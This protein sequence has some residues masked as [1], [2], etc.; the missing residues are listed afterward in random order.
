MPFR[1]GLAAARRSLAG[2]SLNVMNALRQNQAQHQDTTSSCLDWFKPAS[3]SRRL[4]HNVTFALLVDCVAYIVTAASSSANDFITHG[5]PAVVNG[6]IS[7]APALLPFLPNLICVCQPR[8]ATE[9]VD[10]DIE[11]YQ[12]ELDALFQPLQLSLASLEEGHRNRITAE[13]E[14]IKKKLMGKFLEDRSRQLFETVINTIYLVIRGIG[15]ILIMIKG[16]RDLN[17]E[18]SPQLE[19]IGNW[20]TV[21]STAVYLLYYL[22]CLLPN[23]FTNCCA[24]RK[25]P[26][27]EANPS[28][29]SIAVSPGLF[30]QGNRPEPEISDLGLPDVQQSRQQTQLREPLL[31]GPST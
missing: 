1:A 20:M 18:D 5:A 9:N 6:I 3:L 24:P 12:K 31:S 19:E 29:T 16:C 10:A 11:E 17:D 28:L 4:A 25:K 15:G 21:G 8:P 13:I 26:A 7:V 23:R 2:S 27:E 22:V 14:N 30:A